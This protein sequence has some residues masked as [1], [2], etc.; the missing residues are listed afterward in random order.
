MIRHVLPKA[1]PDETLYGAVSRFGRLNGLADH[2]ACEL[3]F[4]DQDRPL[5]SDVLADLE[6]FCRATECAYGGPDEVLNTL[7]LWPFFANLATHPA[8][9]TPVSKPAPPRR[10]PSALGLAALSNSQPHVWRMCTACIAQDLDTFGVAYWHRTH[11]LPGVAVC[12]VHVQHLHELRIPYWARQ[13]CFLGAEALYATF[14]KSPS[15]GKSDCTHATLEIARFAQLALSAR[16]CQL[17]SPTTIQ[18]VILDALGTRGLTNRGG[19][20]N[21]KEFAAQF[22]MNYETLAGCNNYSAYL[23]TKALARLAKALS[24]SPTMIPPTLSVLVAT[25]LFGSWEGFRAHC[26]WRASLDTPLECF[27]L[28]D[29]KRPTSENRKEHR[30]ACL[31]FMASLSGASRTDF[32][33][34]HPKACRWLAQ[35]DCEWLEYRLPITKV[36]APRQLKLF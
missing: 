19:A 1:F 24:N 20:I 34:A 7:T 4:G 9:E 18:G 2:Q 35:F 17:V 6:H 13:K 29:E 36:Y 3:L 26:E 22:I 14:E 23:N 15:H 16:N 32:W 5:V 12:L 30:E 8:I 31:A 11:Q 21:P 25:W 27:P 10:L 33:H 28:E